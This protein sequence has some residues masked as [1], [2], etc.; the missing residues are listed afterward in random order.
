LKKSKKKIEEEVSEN[1]GK[2][3]KLK[4]KD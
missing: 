3:L 1:N 4:K 2:I